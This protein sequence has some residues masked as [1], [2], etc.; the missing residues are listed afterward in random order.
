V[1]HQVEADKA[2][3]RPLVGGASETAI[4]LLVRATRIVEPILGLARGGAHRADRVVIDALADQLGVS[5][6]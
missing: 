6:R 4:E 3:D 2:V 1:D 5:A